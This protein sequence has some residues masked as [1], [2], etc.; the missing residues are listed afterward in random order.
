[1]KFVLEEIFEQKSV[2]EGVL[3]RDDGV[4][5]CLKWVVKGRTT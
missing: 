2:L 4:G 5:K 3:D 1:M